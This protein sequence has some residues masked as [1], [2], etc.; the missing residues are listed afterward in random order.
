MYQNVSIKK[1]DHRHLWRL[2][3]ASMILLC[4]TSVLAVEYESSEV[5]LNSVQSWLKTQFINKDNIEFRVGH[6][7]NRHH[8][9]KCS[10][11]LDVSRPEHTR[12]NG[13]STV[14]VKCHDRNAWQVYVPVR[15]YEYIDVLIAKHALP[16]GT[17][18]QKSDVVTSRKEVSRLH[19]GYFTTLNDVNDMVLKRSLRKGQI[20]TPSIISP[21][22]LVKRGESIIILAQSGNLT[23]R[24]KG[25]A[26]MDGKKGDRIRVKNERTKRELHATVVSSGTVQVSM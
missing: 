17:Y 15:I 2:F 9:L 1:I 16:R 3:A 24:V 10:T 7:D 20:V 25:R 21:P 5:I 6:I 14:K 19:G 11:P 18:I 12:E 8:M 23:I 13:N 22:R 26:L 4:Q